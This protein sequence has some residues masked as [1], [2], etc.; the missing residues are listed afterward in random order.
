MQ[1][2]K[3]ASADVSPPKHSVLERH[4]GLSPRCLISPTWRLVC[5][6]FTEQNKQLATGRV[7]ATP[8]LARTPAGSVR[9]NATWT[10]CRPP[11]TQR[12]SCVPCGTGRGRAVTPVDVPGDSK[13]WNH[14]PRA[15]LRTCDIRAFLRFFLHT[16]NCDFV[17]SKFTLCC[18][19]VF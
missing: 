18:H 2:F 4:R 13:V 10:C 12:R 5:G 16:S 3:Q 9:K 1:M 14:T 7:N 8:L 19:E 6:V 15:A 17:V 11:S